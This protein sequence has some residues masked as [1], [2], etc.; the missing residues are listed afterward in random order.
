MSL[1]FRVED[2]S[3][4]QSPTVLKSLSDG[5]WW[6]QEFLCEWWQLSKPVHVH[7]LPGSRIILAADERLRQELIQ[8]CTY[9]VTI[10]WHV[11]KYCVETIPETGPFAC[12]HAVHYYSHRWKIPVEVP[13]LLAVFSKYYLTGQ[14]HQIRP[15]PVKI[16]A[17]A[18]FGRISKKGPDAGFA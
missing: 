16:L 3:S 8:F 6:C 4:G 9:K 18:G 7:L 5:R 10:S 12:L 14:L 2:D 13:V 1:H 17:G 11:Q 15:N